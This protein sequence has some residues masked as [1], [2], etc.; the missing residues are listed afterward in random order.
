[1]IQFDDKE[2]WCFERQSIYDNLW[3]I[4]CINVTEE[5]KLNSILEKENE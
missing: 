4:V 5:N 2:C 1:M 3:Q